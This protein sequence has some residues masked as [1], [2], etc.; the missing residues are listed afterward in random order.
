MPGSVHACAM[1]HQI[2][3]FPVISW[4]KPLRRQA[5]HGE[6]RHEAAAAID[7][8]LLLLFLSSRHD[9]RE[10]AM[11][12]TIRPVMICLCGSTRFLQALQEAHLRETQAL[13]MVLTVGWD[14]K[15]DA[16]LGLGPD[17][18]GRLDK[19]H[20]RKIDLADEILVLTVEGSIGV[21]TRSE[22]EYA[23][24]HGKRIRCLVENN[25][26]GSE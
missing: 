11:P 12:H 21:S 15:S 4:H 8:S 13:R 6:I 22:I 16:M 9:E 24:Q 26:K 18:K 3:P 5:G 25:Q 23:T 2:S 17:I 20:K 10:D 14:T 1:K 7:Q 19:L